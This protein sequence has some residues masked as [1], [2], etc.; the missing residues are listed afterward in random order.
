MKTQIQHN[1]HT[2]H[3]K[4]DEDGVFIATVPSLKSCYTQAKSMEELLPRIEEV[5]G[6]CL[7]ES[8]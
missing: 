5:M 1:N 6:L 2:V 7:A 8:K 4:T 3:I